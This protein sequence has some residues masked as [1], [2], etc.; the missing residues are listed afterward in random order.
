MSGGVDSSVALHLLKQTGHDVVG[1]HMRNWDASD[2]D[3][4]ACTADQDSEDAAAVC[5]QL[6]VAFREV[7]FV[8]EYWNRVFEPLLDDYAT[9]VVPNPDVA[10][11]REIKFG[12]LLE[13]VRELGCSHLATGHYAR[14]RWNNVAGEVELLPGLDG[15]KD[16]SYFLSSVPQA[17]LQRAIFPLGEMDKG[18]TRRIAEEASLVTASK[19]ESMGICFVGK[20]RKFG[21]FL[22]GYL[23]TSPG[24]VVT[25]AGEV[26]GE[27]QGSGIYTVGQKMPMGG[28]PHKWYVVS[29]DMSRNVVVV[30]EKDSPSLL[31]TSL[32]TSPVQWIAGRPPAGIDPA[33][34][35]LL[36]RFRHG[37][38][39]V[40]ATVEVVPRDGGLAVTFGVGQRAVQRGQTIAF[41]TKDHLDTIRCL[42]GGT[43]TRS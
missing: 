26:V 22:Q 21:D 30:G 17:A 20:R 18:E 39:L 15:H 41:Y 25:E 13:H 38:Q 42:G 28:Q 12:A 24:E 2:E 6:G 5:K 1:V 14:T 4:G 3:P 36:C 7:S 27:H 23:E 11:N 8:K 29:K 40:P 35:D 19:R 33:G 37:Q 32:E 43:I 10:C 16:Q 31:T 9:G 34:E